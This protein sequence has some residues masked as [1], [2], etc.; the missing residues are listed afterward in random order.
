MSEW[1]FKAQKM[2]HLSIVLPEK[3][4]IADISMCSDLVTEETASSNEDEPSSRVSIFLA[5]EPQCVCYKCRGNPSTKAQKYRHPTRSKYF[6]R[7]HML[8]QSAKSQL[9]L[10]P[11]MEDAPRTPAPRL[12]A[13]YASDLASDPSMH[14]KVCHLYKSHESFCS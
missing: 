4:V 11:A 9:S 8:V 10:A 3:A 5:K 13:P 12:N 2:R 7:V 14:A 1:K 6:T